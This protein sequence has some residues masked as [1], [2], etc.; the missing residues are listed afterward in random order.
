MFRKMIIALVVLF[1]VLSMPLSPQAYTSVDKLQ[2]DDV[3]VLLIYA[4][5]ENAESPN[6]KKMIVLL[7]HFTKHVRVTSQVD[8]QKEDI[9]EVSHI[10]YYGEHPSNPSASMQNFIDEFQGSVLV[11]GENVTSFESFGSFQVDGEVRIK[12]IELVRDQTIDHQLDYATLITRV[13]EDE[14]MTVHQY[15]YNNRGL[16]PLFMQKDQRFYFATSEIIGSLEY[17]LADG[18]HEFLPH[19]HTEEHLAYIRLEDIHPMSDPDKLQRVGN[20]LYERGIPFL[21]VVIPVYITPETGEYIHLSE[22]KEVVRVLQDLQQKGGTVISHGYTHQYRD[23]ETGEGF[24]FWDVE[25]N[26]SIIEPYPIDEI[27]RIRGKEEFS[28]EKEYEQYIAPLQEKERAYTEERIEN[29]IHALVALDLPPLAFE[30]PHYTLSQ[31]GYEIVEQYYTAIFG[32]IQYS[33]QDWE[34]MNA[35]PYMTSLPHAQSLTIYP[36]TIGYVD[37]ASDFPIAESKKRLERTLLVRDAVISGF[38]HPYLDTEYMDSFLALF[39][40]LPNVTWLDLKQEAN[41]VQTDKVHI[42]ADG[43]GD[44]HV[45]SSLS[46][47]DQLKR[48]TELTLLDK[49]LWGVTIVVFL[50]VL[51]FLIFTI[52]LRTQQRKRLFKERKING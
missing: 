25:N 24:E 26:Q 36:E 19:T 44:V 10:V 1:T 47:V 20:E 29:A 5:E 15:G 48:Q 22:S 23:S 35:P 39:D 27:E 21:L 8:V 9:D 33:D 6:V 2:D 17:V 50:F 41:E 31:Q 11:I 52:F 45:E 30:A 13:E 16:Y 37:V 38:Y 14:E 32:Q 4:N 34:V 28:N 51:L 18:L 42:V 3:H 46:W 49:I 7:Q 40:D 43:S 12:G